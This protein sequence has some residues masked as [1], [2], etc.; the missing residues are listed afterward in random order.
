M[1]TYISTIEKG[2]IVVKMTFGVGH[3]IIIKMNTYFIKQ[4]SP[5]GSDN[6]AVLT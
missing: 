1:S 4:D 3:K 5:D 2:V 6:R